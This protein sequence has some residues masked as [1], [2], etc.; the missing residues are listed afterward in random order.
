MNDIIT[1]ENKLVE[2]VVCVNFKNAD[3]ANDLEYWQTL[4]NLKKKPYYP[5]SG[6]P[7]KPAKQ[8]MLLIG[9]VNEVVDDYAKVDFG[10][11]NGIHRV[12][13]ADLEIMP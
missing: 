11:Q 2:A 7:N 1:K 12:L 3:Y 5:E 10:S 4:E 8:V 13:I 6:N 9:T